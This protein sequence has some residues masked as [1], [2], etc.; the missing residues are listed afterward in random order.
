[1][2]EGDVQ[3]CEIREVPNTKREYVKIAQTGNE[4]DDGPIWGHVEVGGVREEE[5]EVFR[6]EIPDIDLFKIIQAANSITS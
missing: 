4:K 3:A 2:V 5:R 1:M 6:Q